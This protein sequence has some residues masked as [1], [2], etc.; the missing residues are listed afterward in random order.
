MCGLRKT[1]LKTRP[2]RMGAV[3][4]EEEYCA[5]DWEMIDIQ[6][7]S[8]VSSCAKRDIRSC[9]V[10]WLLMVAVDIE[11]ADDI[12]HIATEARVGV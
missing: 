1:F 11:D 6:S 2:R 12:L 10:S 7:L 3:L 9:L 5:D 4:A 8:L